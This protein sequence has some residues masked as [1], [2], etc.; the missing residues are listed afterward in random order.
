MALVEAARSG[1]MNARPIGF[2]DSGVGGLSILRATRRLLP[3]ESMLYLADNAHFPYGALEDTALQ[4]LAAQVVRFLLAHGAKLIVVA[5]NTATVHTLASLRACFPTVPFIGVVPVVKPLATRTRI[6]ILALLVTPATAASPYLARLVAEHADGRTVITVPCPELAALVEEGLHLDRS[7]GALLQRYLAPVRAGGA[8]V[9]GLGC[10]HYPFL[11]G[12]IQ[13]LVGPDV[14]IIDS[15]Q[16][17]AQRV[18]TVLAERAALA[19][20]G[21]QPRY[22]LYSTGDPAPLGRAVRRYLRLSSVSVEVVTL[23]NG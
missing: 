15:G 23:A 12:R 1:A 2:F 20:P 17:V 21:H 3:A 18:R 10:T 4:V 7:V 16:A 8:D 13:R 14:Q 9:L 5:C 11:R 6:G 22:A 19:E